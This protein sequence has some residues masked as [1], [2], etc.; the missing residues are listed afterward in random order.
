MTATARDMP[1]AK[2]LALLAKGLQRVE[3]TLTAAQ[4]ELHGGYTSTASGMLFSALKH[5]GGIREWAERLVREAEAV[6]A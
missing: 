4:V 5:V 6:N 2:D 1:A 3:A